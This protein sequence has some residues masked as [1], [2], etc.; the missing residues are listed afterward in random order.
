MVLFETIFSRLH[1]LF[2][3]NVFVLFFFLFFFFLGGGGV[4]GLYVCVWRGGGGL[5]TNSCNGGL[6]SLCRGLCLI[7]DDLPDLSKEKTSFLKMRDSCVLSSV[8]L[9]YSVFY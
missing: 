3:L 7:P 1:V 6:F 4:G 9:Q 2:C 8:K 5:P